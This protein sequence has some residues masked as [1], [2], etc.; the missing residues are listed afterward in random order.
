MQTS[1][2]RRLKPLHVAISVVACLVAAGTSVFT[3]FSWS[4]AVPSGRAKLNLPAEFSKYKEW[5]PLHTSPIAV[6]L[7]LWTL[8]IA[9]TQADWARARQKYG[10]HNEHYIQ[11]YGNQMAMQAFGRKARHFLTGAVIAKEKLESPNGDAEG[12]AF[13]IKRGTPQFAKT[14]GWEFIYYPQSGDSGR[15][16]EHCAECHQ[17]AASTDYVFGQYPR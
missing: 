6:P 16:Q 1:N 8:C 4:Q 15:T 5:T 14:D 2:A 17:A 7:Y 10:P 13:M 3:V 9:P 12:V 11:V